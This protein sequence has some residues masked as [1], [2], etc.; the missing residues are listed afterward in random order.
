MLDRCGPV[1]QESRSVSALWRFFFFLFPILSATYIS[2]SS[3]RAIRGRTSG[4]YQLLN[5]S[6]I[7]LSF[8]INYGLN[9]QHSSDNT[10][11]II[12]Q[13]AFALQCLPGLI[14]LVGILFQPESPRWT[15]E[16]GKFDQAVKGEKTWWLSAWVVS[17]SFSRANLN[18]PFYLSFYIQIFLIFITW[19]CMKQKV[20]LT[21][22]ETTWWIRATSLSSLKSSTPSN[23]KP[24]STDS[25]RNERPKTEC[26]VAHS[27][28]PLCL[29]YEMYPD[30]A[31]RS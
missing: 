4:M 9:L 12:W 19:L 10:N 2:E 24:S 5:V 29:F 7:M 17:R 21:R 23:P 26:S 8:F 25:Q 1:F 20:S 22:S 6:G 31:T 28:L 16:H 30:W 14:F 15:V 3:P 18:L 11:P 13:I 27:P